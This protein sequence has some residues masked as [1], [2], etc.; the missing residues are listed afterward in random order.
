MSEAGYHCQCIGIP[1]SPAPA[2]QAI[3]APCLT[4]GSLE[5]W[6]TASTALAL[7][8]YLRSQGVT[9]KGFVKALLPCRRERSAAV[10]QY[11]SYP[12]TP[13]KGLGAAAPSVSVLPSRLPGGP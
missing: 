9:A 3:S 10:A 8:L 11:L 6:I 7:G 1:S 4:E 13:S 2:K 12:C 5:N